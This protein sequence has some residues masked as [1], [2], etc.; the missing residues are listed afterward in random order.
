MVE[1]GYYDG[2]ESSSGSGGQLQAIEHE[3]A[4]HT[5]GLLRVKVSQQVGW[6][7]SEQEFAQAMQA[8]AMA[9]GIQPGA[10]AGQLHLDEQA[11]EQIAG[12]V[13]AQAGQRREAEGRMRILAG[14]WRELQQSMHEATD[15]PA[16]AALMQQITAL[17]QQIGQ[18]WCRYVMTR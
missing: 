10:G 8:Y 11:F 12:H 14:Q 3:M 16:K 6:L 18:L 15:E 13:R 5:Q 17:E 7:I 1:S 4:R 2:Y 9:Q